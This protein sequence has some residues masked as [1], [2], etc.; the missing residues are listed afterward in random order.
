MD[1]YIQLLSWHVVLA[2]LSGVLSMAAM[3]PYVRDVLRG[4]ETKPN[5]VSFGLWTVLQGIALAAQIQSGASWSVVVVFFV[6]LNTLIITVLALSGFGYRAYG[7]I[8]ALSFVL[9]IV[10]IVGWFKTGDPVLAIWFTIIADFFASVPT[11]VK[12]A[13]DPRSE[14]SMAWGLVTAAAILGG[15]STDRMDA[16]NVAFPAYLVLM[17]GTIFCLSYFGR[18]HSR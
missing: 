14:Q 10:A 8:D 9:A 2:M 17:N 5:A 6:T 7:K 15:L 13:R 3:V 4:G 16:A 12:T 1:A 18:K 11:V